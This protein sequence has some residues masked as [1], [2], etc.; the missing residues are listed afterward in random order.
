MLLLLFKYLKKGNYN[1]MLLF[2]LP[3]I[4]LLLEFQLKSI[5]ITSIIYLFTL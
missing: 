2:D 5:Q 3:E 1:T 4:Y